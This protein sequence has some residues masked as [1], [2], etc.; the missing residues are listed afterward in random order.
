MIHIR[1]GLNSQQTQYLEYVIPATIISI[2][3][4][5]DGTSV[6]TVAGTSVGTVAGTAVGTVAG[7]SV[8]TVA[9]TSVGTVAGQLYEQ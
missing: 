1:I 5:H 3:C 7:T 4:M 8:G 9:G 6:G 2:T